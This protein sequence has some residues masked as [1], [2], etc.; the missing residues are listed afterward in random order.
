MTDNKKE[1][2]PLEVKLWKTKKI[3]FTADEWLRA[4]NRWSV[5]SITILSLYIIILSIHSVVNVDI[6]NP[7]YGRYIPVI[8]L[9]LSVYI[10]IISLFEG[11]K[12]Y[13]LEADK[14]HRCG[15]E[16]Q[17]E[18]HKLCSPSSSTNISDELRKE[19][20]DNYDKILVK[21]PNHDEK[22]FEIFKAKNYWESNI[23][24]G[25]S[26]CIYS[27]FICA[28]I[29]LAFILFKELW[30]YLLFILSPLFLFTTDFFHLTP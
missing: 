16:I 28:K 25:P 23:N 29:K 26:D 27:K 10:L 22:Y 5:F 6:V 17:A 24:V 13:I 4:K 19:I 2:D 7:L 18:H 9:I 21:Y 3:R 20:I 12:N 11:S 14:M 30:L 15:L 1:R 8:V